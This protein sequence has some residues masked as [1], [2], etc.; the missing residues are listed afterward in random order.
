MSICVL[1][2][3]QNLSLYL[4]DTLSYPCY[5]DVDPERNPS[6][7][8]LKDALTPVSCV[9]LNLWLAFEKGLLPFCEWWDWFWFLSLAQSRT[10]CMTLNRYLFSLASVFS[11][12]ECVALKCL[13]DKMLYSTAIL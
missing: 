3:G 5:N 13:I 4:I 2:T 8:L 12:F 6:F 1:D 10:S 7:C 11:S 9:Y